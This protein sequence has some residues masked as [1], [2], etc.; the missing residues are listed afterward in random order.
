[1]YLEIPLEILNKM[2]Y[3]FF[4]LFYNTTIKILK[5]I[6]TDKGF[7]FLLNILKFIYTKFISLPFNPIDIH[8]NFKMY[9][10]Y[11]FLISNKHDSNINNHLNN[12]TPHHHH[13]NTYYYGC[14]DMEKKEDDKFNQDSLFM[15]SVSP[16][17][18]VHNNNEE[19]Y[20]EEKSKNDSTNNIIKHKHTNEKFNEYCNYNMLSVN[21]KKRISIGGLVPIFLTSQNRNEKKKQKKNNG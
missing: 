2:R 1:M 9:D 4:E 18:F 20:N 14:L 16:L 19:E 10:F 21:K 17:K 12:N 5:F 6:K 7:L 3:S 8:T 11:E 13:N 15:N